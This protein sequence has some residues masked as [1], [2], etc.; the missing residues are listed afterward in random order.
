MM[1]K[2]NCGVA[3]WVS[4]TDHCAPQFLPG[5]TGEKLEGGIFGQHHS[6]Q[7]SV[8]GRAEHD[9]P[10]QARIGLAMP[11]GQVVADHNV[12]HAVG[13]E[14]DLFD[15][16]EVGDDPRQRLGVFADAALGAGIR[17][18]EGDVAAALVQIIGQRVHHGMAAEQSVQED[19]GPAAHGR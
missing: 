6:G 9:H 16:V 12:A 4:K 19:H 7:R 17:D 3:R 11:F 15:A 14:V 18:V 13:D 2:A 8:V 10:P 1:P 5:L